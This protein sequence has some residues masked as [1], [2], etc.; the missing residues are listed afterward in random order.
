LFLF[1]KIQTNTKLDNC[2]LASDDAPVPQW[3]IVSWL[4]QHMGCK[5]PIEK[6]VDNMPDMN[7]RCRNMRLKQLGY[8][9]IHPDFKSGYGE[10]IEK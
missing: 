10:L 2:Y 1:E 9:F 4:S 6:P 8:R 5:D 3:D 7:K